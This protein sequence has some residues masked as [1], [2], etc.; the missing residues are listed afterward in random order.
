VIETSGAISYDEQVSGG[1][2]IPVSYSGTYQ[3]K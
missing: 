3:V 2:E 1:E